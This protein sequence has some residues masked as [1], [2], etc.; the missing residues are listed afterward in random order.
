MYLFI[1]KMHKRSF[2]EISCTNLYTVPLV[3]SSH[4]SVFM[5][6]VSVVYSPGFGSIQ[7]RFRYYTAPGSVVYSPDFGSIQYINTVR[8]TCMYINTVRYTRMYIPS[9][10]VLLFRSLQWR[11]DNIYTISIRSSSLQALHIHNTHASSFAIHVYHAT[12]C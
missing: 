11:F 8:Y 4:T 2:K 5:V 7:S 12:H 10:Y 6:P 1:F 3:T 9:M